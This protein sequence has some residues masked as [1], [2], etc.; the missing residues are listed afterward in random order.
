MGASGMSW[1]AS[2]P[3]IPPSYKKP[4]GDPYACWYKL[5]KVPAWVYKDAKMQV[6]FTKL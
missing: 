4:A 5:K 2:Y 6:K 1:S 3:A